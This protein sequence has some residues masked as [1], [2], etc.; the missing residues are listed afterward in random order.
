MLPLGQLGVAKESEV[1]APVNSADRVLKKDE[2][3]P[4]LKRLASKLC[5]YLLYV[6]PL[7]AMVVSVA[8][9]VTVEVTVS[10][11]VTDVVVVLES[12]TMV[13]LFVLGQSLRL[14]R[15]WEC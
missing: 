7:D 1:R 8:Y 9:A 12:V 4:V 3:N 6:T 11:V 5:V 2:E 10:V 14:E 13:V 15:S